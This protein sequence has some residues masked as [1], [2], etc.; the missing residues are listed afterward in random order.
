DHLPVGSQ[1]AVGEAILEVT[2]IP[3]LGCKKFVARFG[4]DALT[5]INSGRGKRLR[6]RG[7]NARVVRA[8]TVRRGDAIRKLAAGAAQSTL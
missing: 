5:F 6:L 8:G 3:H 1:F 7:L 2:P 4:L